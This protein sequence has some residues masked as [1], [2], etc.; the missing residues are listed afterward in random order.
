MVAR[1]D[2]MFNF[3]FHGRAQ[4]SPTKLEVRVESVEFRVELPPLPKGR[5]TACGG[6]IRFSLAV[7]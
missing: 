1:V 2:L 3:V 4:L 5:G 7:T 6:G